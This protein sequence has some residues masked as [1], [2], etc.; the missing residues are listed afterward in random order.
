MAVL[1]L[2]VVGIGQGGGDASCIVRGSSPNEADLAP[3]VNSGE[4]G[5]ED[6]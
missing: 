3:D 1:L 4:G 5:R 6:A 2:H